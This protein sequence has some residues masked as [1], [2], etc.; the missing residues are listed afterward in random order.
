MSYNRRLPVYLILDCS[1]SLAGEPFESLRQ[2]IRALLADLRTNPLAL[3][4]VAISVITFATSSRQVM[5]LTDLLKVAE[6]SLRL[7]SGTALGSALKLWLQCLDKEVVRSSATQK[8]DWKPIAILITD[9]EPTDDWE[10]I[11]DR[12]R[13]EIVGKR[14]NLIA[15]ACGPDADISKL[16]RITETVLRAA[17]LQPGTINRLFKWVS[18][19]VSTASQKLESANNQGIGLP[20]LPK[21]LELATT[22]GRRVTA[23]KF[24]YLHCRCRGNGAFYL[25]KYRLVDGAYCADSAIPI[26]DFE[27]SEGGKNETASIRSDRITDSKP[28]PYCHSPF[29]AHCPCGGV[30]CC[31]PISGSVELTC[32]WC[33]QSAT[34]APGSFDVGRGLG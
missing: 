27:L 4:T 26:E 18:A 33:K 14:A 10:S 34:Y 25:L 19:S 15:I 5:P 3:E 6:P 17:D 29:W 24:I 30:L 13:T 32:P 1:E 16:K 7:G 12:V 22:G 20:A 9:G 21:E 23:D 8:G 2:G 28:C 11:A 31:P